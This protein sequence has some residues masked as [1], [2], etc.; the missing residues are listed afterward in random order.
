MVLKASSTCTNDPIGE[1]LCA[2]HV[3]CGNCDWELVGYGFI[4]GCDWIVLD[5]TRQMLVTSVL[6]I[7]LVVV[8]CFL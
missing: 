6:H 3:S 1:D 7:P 5:T 2:G 8:F 4:R